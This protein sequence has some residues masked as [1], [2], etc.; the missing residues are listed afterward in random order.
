MGKPVSMKRISLILLIVF[1]IFI[2][3]SVLLVILP[4]RLAGP[5]NVLRL[6]LSGVA[7]TFGVAWC[8]LSLLAVPRAIWFLVRRHARGALNE[9]RRTG[10]IALLL[11]CFPFVLCL[12]GLM[13]ISMPGKHEIV[14]IPPLTAD[15]R[16]LCEALKAD[17]STLAGTIGDR[18]VISRYDALC[19]AADYIEGSLV[20]AGYQVRRQEYEVDWLKGRPCWNLEV[21]I[22]GSLHPEEIVIIG[23]HYDSV[24]GVPGA[25]DNASGVAGML[26]LA[27]TFAGTKPD[28]TLRFVAFVNEEPPFFWTSN[29][30]SRVYARQCK[31]RHEKI[32]AML[33]LETIG[34]Y[35]DE[36]NSQHYPLR[37]F[38]LFYPTTGNFVG[39]IGNI[40]S[41]SLVRSVAASFN[42]AGFCPS[43]LAAMPSWI[44][45]ISWSDHS[46]FWREGYPAVM[47]TD[48][49]LFRYQWYH[50]PDDRP[51]KLNYERFA[52]AVA[53]LKKVVGDLAGVNS[54]N[55]KVWYS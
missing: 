48:T 38:N 16:L 15:Q 47:V 12:A 19:A 52:L 22:R 1:V 4:F 14:S 50:T 43:E 31:A 37:V 30:G 45:G 6:I 32:V 18:N 13:M 20:K 5:I 9:N 42:Q 10:I 23:A 7:F 21:E 17:V 24:E 55:K 2:I 25:N 40:G 34:Y 26:A 36:K 54:P 27:R 46:S 49:A 29:M 28:R 33:S 11:G 35:S 53:G 8:V 44:T 39:F 3:S 41:R 51:E